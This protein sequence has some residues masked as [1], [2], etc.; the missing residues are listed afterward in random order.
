MITSIDHLII[1]VEN[2]EEAESNY[3]KIL[4]IPSSWKGEHKDFGTSNCLFNFKNTYLELLA[5]SGDGLGADFIKQHIKENGEGFI[6]ISLGTDNLD[7]FSNVLKKNNFSVPEIIFGEGKNSNN[8]KTRVWKNLFLPDDLTRGMFSFIIQHLS[9]ELPMQKAFQ[10]EMASKLD[11]VVINTN[12]ADGFINI[13]RDIF[14]IRLALDKVIESWNRR[15]LYFRV[16]KTTIEVIESKN[17][18]PAK[19]SL[20][21]LAWEVESLEKACNRLQKEQVEVSSIKKG[22]KENTLVA[23][24]KS[25]T[26]NV[27]TL[28]IEHLN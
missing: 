4:G 15:M 13:Y 16:N 17:E 11:H 12:D 1:A 20:W 8:D 2:L 5:A 18:E 27:P 19:D 28:L 14:K 10:P 9:A 6:G 7:N 22:I 26:H 25:H 24:I 23:T 3:T 21:G